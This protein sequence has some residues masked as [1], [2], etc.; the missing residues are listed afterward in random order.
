M[1][2]HKLAKVC[3]STVITFSKYWHLNTAQSI[4]YPSGQSI[5]RLCSGIFTLLPLT[6]ADLHTSLQSDDWC[7]MPIGN[8]LIFNTIATLSTQ[9]TLKSVLPTYTSTYAAYAHR[10]NKLPI[11]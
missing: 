5:Y 4:F 11:K 9:H 7:F 2:T 1:G 8:V 6:I 10:M 3:S